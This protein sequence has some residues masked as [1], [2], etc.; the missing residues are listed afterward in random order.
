MEWICGLGLPVALV[1]V[2]ARRRRPLVAVSPFESIST[3][4][5]SLL[6]KRKRRVTA[7]LLAASDLLR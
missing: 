4:H 3:L 6:R 5:T 1:A 2:A 7:A